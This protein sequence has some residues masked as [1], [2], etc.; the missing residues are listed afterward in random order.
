[1]CACYEAQLNIT[2]QIFCLPTKHYKTSILST[3]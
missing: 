2:K 3:N 1:L